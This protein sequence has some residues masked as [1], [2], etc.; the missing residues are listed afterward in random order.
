MAET[1]STTIQVEPCSKQTY[2]KIS[3]YQA[4]MNNYPVFNLPKNV[5][6]LEDEIIFEQDF[7]NFRYPS[8]RFPFD[9]YY[10][11]DQVIVELPE[12]EERTR[13]ASARCDETQLRM[14][15]LV[16]F[17]L[18]S[19]IFFFFCTFFFIW[20]YEISAYLVIPFMSLI[21]AV[22]FETNFV[23]QFSCFFSS[24]ISPRFTCITKYPAL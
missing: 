18:S 2:P 3:L 21:F 11:P 7:P 17:F 22:S 24:F 15:M 16:F 8:S 20:A 1:L 19:V 4:K 14:V 10:Q 9:Y 12:T 23:S 6:K 5:M 13:T